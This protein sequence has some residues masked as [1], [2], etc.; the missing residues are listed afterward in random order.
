MFMRTY[1]L[2][3]GYETY[4]PHRVGEEIFNVVP[5]VDEVPELPDTVVQ[6]GFAL[7]ECN[8]IAAGEPF[9][10]TDF[11]GYFQ[12]ELRYYAPRRA[13][14]LDEFSFRGIYAETAELTGAH[15]AALLGPIAAI[16][17]RRGDYGTGYFFIAPNEWYVDDL[18]RLQEHTPGLTVYIATDDR[19]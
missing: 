1:A 6:K 8:I 16:H 12:Y 19:S 2:D 4:L 14:F 3:H 17:L 11:V 13:L 18:R 15:F 5:G 7:H 10:E 9:P